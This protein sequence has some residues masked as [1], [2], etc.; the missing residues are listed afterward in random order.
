MKNVDL[1]LSRLKTKTPPNHFSMQK[2]QKRW[3]RDEL[4]L[5]MNLYCKTTFGRLHNRNPD[6]VELAKLIGRTASA[7]AYKLVNFASLDPQ[8]QARGIKGAQNASKLDNEVWQEFH[9]NWDQL[10]FEGERLLANLKKINL[11]DY[12]DIPGD[13]LPRAGTERER[14]IKTRVNQQLFRRMVLSAYEDRC[15][16]TGINRPELL[17]AGHIKPWSSDIINRMNPRNGLAINALHDKAF[18]NGLITITPDYKIKISSK[19]KDERNEETQNYFLRYEDK[20]IFLP[21]RFIPTP[22][23]LIFHNNE[24]FIP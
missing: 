18:E 24:R 23:L 7:V 21:F 8:L 5:V 9:Q 2:G 22:E 6:V 12:L 14:V 3:T 19:L 4:I 13:E 17:I 16:I 1:N 11:E 20:P 15:C 10:P